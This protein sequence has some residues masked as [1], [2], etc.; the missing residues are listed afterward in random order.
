[1]E[2]CSINWGDY[3]NPLWT[4]HNLYIDN[5]LIT[6][7]VVPDGVSYIGRNAF[8]RCSC[9]NSITIPNSVKTINERAFWYCTNLTSINFDGTKVEWQAISKGEEWHNQVPSNCVVHCIGEDIKIAN[10]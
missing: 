8:D 9:L 2:W 10:A 7:L 6:D 3:S 5:Q 4:A 1:M